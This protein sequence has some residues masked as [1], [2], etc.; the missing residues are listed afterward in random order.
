VGAGGAAP[1]RRIAAGNEGLWAAMKARM[2]RRW[3]RLASR[4][5]AGNRTVR[6]GVDLPRRVS[7]VHAVDAAGHVLGSRA[8]ARDKFIAWRAQLPAGCMQ[9]VG[10]STGL[11]Q[12]AAQQRLWT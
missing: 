7:Q 5:S 3:P 2:L 9:Q 11:G 1:R 10:W 6:V 4:E 12:I 8:L